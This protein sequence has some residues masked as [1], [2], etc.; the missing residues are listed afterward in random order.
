MTRQLTLTQPPPP[1]PGDAARPARRQS[2]GRRRRRVARHC[3]RR[4]QLLARNCSAR[5]SG[6]APE[7][8]GKAIEDR[9]AALIAFVG[10]G[11]GAPIDSALKLLNDLQQQLRRWR[12][13]ARAPR[14]PPAGGGDPAQMLQAE[15][16]HDPQPV[17][18]WLV[19]AG[20]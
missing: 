1:V 11:P 5:T 17:Q 14:L 9:Y 20:A 3:D 8:P 4:R 16:S 15:A 19:G 10:K 6:P 13:P 2:A 18:R 12:M 7:P